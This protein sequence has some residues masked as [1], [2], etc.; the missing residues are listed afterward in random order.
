[1]MEVLH[2]FVRCTT[3]NQMLEFS[4]K[5]SYLS[6]SNYLFCVCQ[7]TFPKGICGMYMLN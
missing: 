3:E 6:S 4:V 5:L 1:M 2:K 7:A